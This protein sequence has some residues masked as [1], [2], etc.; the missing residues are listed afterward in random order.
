MRKPKALKPGDTLGVVSPASGLTQVQLDKGLAYLHEQGFKTKLFPH[1]LDVDGFLAGRDEDRARDLMQAFLDP[2]VD[3]IFCSRGGYGCSRLMPF[4]DFDAILDHPK[5]LIGFSDLTVLHAA[6]NRRGL[7]TLHAPMALTLNTPR[8]PWVYQSLFD[9]MKGQNPI[10]DAAPK[11]TML[12]PGLATGQ[13][14]GGCLIL[15]VDLIGTSEQI[16]MAGKIVLIEDVDEMPH[17]IDA[18]L[19]HLINAGHLQKAAGILIGEMT[20]TD[21][22]T[23][24]AI[25][26]KPWREIVQERLAPLGI[27]TIIDFP[28]G[29]A[30]QMLSLPLGIHAKLNANEGTLTYLEPLCA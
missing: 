7:P 26:G 22:R 4:L 27:P 30:P 3:A 29:H 11:G 14:V 15:I 17:R 8:Q 12:V 21:D 24:K 6:L 20:R 10:I 28:C 18:K 25:G 5:M 23:D 9:A 16:D 13:L 1:V 2:T 19:T